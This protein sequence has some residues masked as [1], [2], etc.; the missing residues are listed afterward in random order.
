MRRVALLL[1]LLL[2]YAA[3]PPRPDVRLR[4]FNA[5]QGA[6]STT[7]TWQTEEEN[8]AQSFRL[9][10]RAPSTSRGFA[11]VATLPAHGSGRRYHYQDARVPAQTGEQVMYRLDV[12]LDSGLRQTIPLR[13]AGRPVALIPQAWGSIKAMFQ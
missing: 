6:A 11:Q 2:V 8:E 9:Y 7:L 5:E 4:F 1:P 3:A 12:V 10:R 13:P